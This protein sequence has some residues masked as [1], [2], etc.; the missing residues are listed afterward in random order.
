MGTDPDIAESDRIIGSSALLAQLHDVLRLKHD[1][2]RTEVAYL[3]WINRCILIASERCEHPRSGKVRRPHFDPSVVQKAVNRALCAA[4]VHR[5][6]SPH[7]LPPSFAN[8]ILDHGYDIRA[9]QQLIRHSD[10]RT[11]MSTTRYRYGAP[12]ATRLK[13]VEL[14]EQSQPW[15]ASQPRAKRSHRSTE[16]RPSDRLV[17][18]SRYNEIELRH[19]VKQVRRIRRP[20]DRMWEFTYP[21]IPA[22]G[23]EE[24]IVQGAENYPYVDI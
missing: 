14:V 8:H 17:V 4:G 23:L 18:R 21:Q 15:S 13:T 9:V 20:E 3:A 10:V 2:I 1:S 6:A 7:A 12:T 11:T 16:P 19:R 24:R 5:K 22:M